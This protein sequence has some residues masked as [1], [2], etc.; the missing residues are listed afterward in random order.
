MLEWVGFNGITE[1]EGLELIEQ[2][3]EGGFFSTMAKMTPLNY[4][5]IFQTQFGVVGE[6]STRNLN[7]VS[8]MTGY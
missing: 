5:F 2:A 6:K 8:L 3:A 7:T 4:M 1:K